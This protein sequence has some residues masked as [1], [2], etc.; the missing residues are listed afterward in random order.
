M[1][2]HHINAVL[3]AIEDK[4]D[5]VLVGGNAI[6]VWVRHYTSAPEFAVSDVVTTRDIDFLGT[7]KRARELAA[8]VD[9]SIRPA[10]GL[11][12]RTI[13]G[14][15]TQSSISARRTRTMNVSTSSITS[16]DLAAML[17]VL[18]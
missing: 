8:A 3:R 9:A 10:S 14:Q 16:K 7:P 2:D 18:Q 13:S 11:P 15:A 17:Y 6:V 5:V 4:P 12:T 1:D